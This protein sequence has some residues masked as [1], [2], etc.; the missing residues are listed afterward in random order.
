[1]PRPLPASPTG[2]GFILSGAEGTATGCT[3]ATPCTFSALKT[4]L[5]AGTGAKILT[6]GITKGRD[7]AWQGAVDGLRVNGTVYD[8]EPFGV[9]ETTP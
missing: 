3:L 8:F 4:A 2:T 5:Q 7:F 9:Q 1:M 6:V